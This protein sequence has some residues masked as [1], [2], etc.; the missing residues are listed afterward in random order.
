MLDPPQYTVEVVVKRTWPMTFEGVS[1]ETVKYGREVQ[2]YRKQT[3][4]LVREGAPQR[5]HS[6][7]QTENN[8]WSQ[9]PEWTWHQ[10]ILTDWPSVVTWLWLWLWLWSWGSR[11]F[12]RRV[13][14]LT[15]P[16]SNCTSKLETHPLV[17]EGV[18]HQETHNR[19][20]EN[21]NLVMGSRCE[22]DTKANCPTDRR[23]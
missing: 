4:P 19:Q 17:R 22:P 16:R 23:S 15:R 6:K 12:N 14:A 10:D 21:K 18:P 8:I 9:V 11:D 3:R 13:T 7:F 5:Q 2:D 1:H 20:T